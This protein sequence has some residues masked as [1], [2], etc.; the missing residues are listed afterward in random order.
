[1]IHPLNS[2][3]LV[4]TP[5][6]PIDA[7]VPRRHGHADAML[8][9]LMHVRH[10]PLPILIYTRIIR[11]RTSLQAKVWSGNHHDVPSAVICTVTSHFSPLP[12]PYP[13]PRRFFTNRQILS[14]SLPNCASSAAPP[15]PLPLTLSFRFAMQ[16]P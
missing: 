16:S 8:P 2:S 13:P 15:L 4:V 7:V 10:M 9:L 5:S 14:L 6:V 11:T 3:W 12:F 1:M